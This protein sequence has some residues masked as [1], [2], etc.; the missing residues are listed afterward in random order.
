MENLSRKLE[1]ETLLEQYRKEL[2]VKIEKLQKNKAVIFDGNGKIVSKYKA[3]Y[4][5]LKKEIYDALLRYC[6]EMLFCFFYIPNNPKGLEVAE[7]MKSV[8]VAEYTNIRKITISTCSIDKID[9]TLQDVRQKI[10]DVWWEGLY[11]V[12]S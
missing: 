11:I 6:T 10:V 8:F 12:A 4:I 5:N 3:A 1:E 7:K 9:E 2:V